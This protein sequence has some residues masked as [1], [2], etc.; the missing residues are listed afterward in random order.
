MDLDLLSILR[1]YQFSMLYNVL[2]YLLTEDC[3]PDYGVSGPLVVPDTAMTSSTEF[4]SRHGASTAR[5][6]SII[7]NMSLLCWRPQ[8]TDTNPWLQVT[9]M[10]ILL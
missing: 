7:P 8:T 3:N 9:T 6:R 5:I 4:D 1:L 2:W 10:L